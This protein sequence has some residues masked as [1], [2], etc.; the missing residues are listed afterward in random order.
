MQIIHP[1]EVIFVSISE[2]Y[3]ASFVWFINKFVEM[4]F[5]KLPLLIFI[6]KCTK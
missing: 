2:E 5:L 4:G 3:I 6:K 1:N